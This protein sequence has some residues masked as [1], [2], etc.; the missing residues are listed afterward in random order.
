MENDALHFPAAARSLFLWCDSTRL[1]VAIRDSTWMFA[2]FE[3]L[4]LF[5]LAILLGSLVVFYLRLLGLG[6]RRQPVA[7][8]A[9]ELAPWIRG[10]LV[11][12]LGTGLLLFFSE[13]MKC[14]ASPPFAIK[15]LLLS[16]AV[17]SHLV[18]FRRAMCIKDSTPLP[19]W[20]RPAACLSLALW[21]GVGL[22]GRAI[23][24]Q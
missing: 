7:Q 5:G 14:Y 12:M 1:S 8:L 24:F 20:T 17:V 19:L 10:G 15:M 18:I 13:A 4:H 3:I 6:M 21:F 11:F 2:V 22:A 23:G 16:L 9:A